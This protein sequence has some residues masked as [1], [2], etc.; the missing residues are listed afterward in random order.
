MGHSAWSAVL[1]SRM[2]CSSR[3]ERQH[4]YVSTT[5]APRQ[6]HVSSAVVCGTR[7]GGAFVALVAVLKN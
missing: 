4:R 5:P 6:H 7:M 2:V 3:S 1:A